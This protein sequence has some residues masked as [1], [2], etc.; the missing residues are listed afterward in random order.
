MIGDHIPSPIERPIPFEAIIAVPL[1]I[2]CLVAVLDA[3][4]LGNAS[5][6]VMGLG[7]VSCAAM[8]VWELARLPSLRRELQALEQH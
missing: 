4:G 5:L 8:T 6:A 1:T 3:V 7:A 2:W